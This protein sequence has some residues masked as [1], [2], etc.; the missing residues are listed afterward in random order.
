MININSG[1]KT[2]FK[3]DYYPAVSSMLA[4][5][6]EIVFASVPVT[7]TAADLSGENFSLNEKL[8]S[9]DNLVIGACED[10][11]IKF[12]IN[13]ELD[14]SGLE[15]TIAQ[16]ITGY[17]DIPLGKY[18]VDSCIQQEG[19]PLKDIVAYGMMKKFDVD[20]ADW[21]KALTFPITLT[22]LYASLC[23]HVGVTK[24][25]QT[26]V[27]G[28]ISITKTLDAPTT[29][30]GRDVL[31]RICELTGG[32]GNI[33][34][35]GNISIINL[36]TS[37]D[38]S[39]PKKVYAEK[40]IASAITKLNL[41]TEAGEILGASGTGTN[42]YTIEGNFLIYDMAESDLNTIASNIYTVISGKSY[43]P[44]TLEC[45]GLPYIEVGDMI[46]VVSIN[47]TFSSYVFERTLKGI[48]CLTDDFVAK[49]DSTIPYD[50]S[51]TKQVERAADQ[52][53]AVVSAYANKGT[54]QY[55]YDG[56]TYYKRSIVSETYGSPNA[57]RSRRAIVYLNP[58]CDQAVWDP[59]DPTKSDKFTIDTVN[60]Y[61][62][63]GS[64]ID[65]D[66]PLTDDDAGEGIIKFGPNEIREWTTGVATQGNYVTIRFSADR[67][68]PYIRVTNGT[69]TAL[70]KIFCSEIIFPADTEYTTAKARNGKIVALADS[71]V[72]G[73]TA[74][75]PNGT[76]I[77]V[78]EV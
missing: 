66:T 50:S 45:F 51:L 44:Y 43:R 13:T 30:K 27:N 23:T 34:R 67:T 33:T 58:N 52:S 22:N 48:Q 18:V 47:E 6:L 35:Y 4:K 32:F 17:D 31:H 36:G 65:Y 55:V 69:G 29:L 71:P 53:A 62:Q 9:S 37:A 54:Y 42:V 39:V 68:N 59:A 8:C 72:D 20:V 56:T 11:V 10:S 3:T 26:L 74:T 77:Y 75:E 21:Y 41:L 12:T 28:S 70:A 46:S 63:S 2:L 25:T 16:T 5:N 7:F 15:F 60:R 78:K 76:I 61:A 64:V 38:A 57:M 14:L 24:E 1:L 49:G 40:Y 73:G 19:L